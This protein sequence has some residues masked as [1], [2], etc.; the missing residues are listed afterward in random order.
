MPDLFC[1][2]CGGLNEVGFYY[3]ILLLIFNLN[4]L[5]DRISPLSALVCPFD[6]SCHGQC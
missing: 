2:L 5:F 3:G 4:S 1:D 6:V